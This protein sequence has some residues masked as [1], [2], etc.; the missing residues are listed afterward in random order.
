MKTKLKALLL[1]GALCASTTAFAQGT[2]RFDLV[3]AWGGTSC[4]GSLTLD[5]SVVHPNSAFWPGADPNIDHNFNGSGAYGLSI[6]TPYGT[7]SDRDLIAVTT[8][9]GL[10]PDVMSHFDEN[11]KLVLFVKSW[12][13]SAGVRCE[14]WARPWDAS[15]EGY[16]VSIFNY[17][18]SHNQIGGWGGKFVQAPEPSSAA[19]LGLGLMALYVKRAANR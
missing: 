11:G 13:D 4:H 9:P 17:D 8:M 12:D 6:T 5:A 16:D 7:W 10:S 15:R 14:V 18:A 1:T 2:V 3:E 19:L